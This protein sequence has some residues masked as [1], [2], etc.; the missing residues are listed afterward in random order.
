MKS[1][2]KMFSKSSGQALPEYIVGVLVIVAALFTRL[3]ILDNKTSVEFITDAF[4]K[5]YRGYEFAMSQP[6]NE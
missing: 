3:P 6:A 1:G 4:Q 2:K 5:N